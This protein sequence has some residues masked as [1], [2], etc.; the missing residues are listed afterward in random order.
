[1]QGILANPR[2]L[3]RVEQTPARRAPAQT[4]RI[5]DVDLASRLSFFLWGTLPD[6]EL[7]KAAS[8]RRRCSTPAVFEKQ[9]KRMLADPRSRRAGDA[10]RVAV[11][12]AAGCRQDSPGRPAVSRL[13]RLARRRRCV[14]ETELFFDSIVREDRSVL[15]LLTADY[16]FVNERL[17][18]HYGIPNVTGDEFR[19]VH[20]ARRR[21]AACSGRAASCC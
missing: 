14:S 6:A 12:A 16:T 11:A 21:A 8:R 5:A 13:R 17:A 2:F 3:F 20:A 19:R 9:V 1:M 18:R 7:M 10:L 15:D 4:Y